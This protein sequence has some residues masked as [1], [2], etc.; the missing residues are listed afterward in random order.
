MTIKELLAR[1]MQVPGVETRERAETVVAAVFHTLRD[2]LTPGEADDVWAQLPTAW[3]DIWESGNWTAKIR[4]RLSGAHSLDRDEF[5]QRV[6]QQIPHDIAAE[7]AVRVVF[8][9]LKDQISPG[10]TE[11]V[12]AQLPRDLRNLWK[13]A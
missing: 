4:A 3:K 12:S 7:D 11:D 9:A 5:V 1:V 13:A 6:Q 2:R 10:E 8:H